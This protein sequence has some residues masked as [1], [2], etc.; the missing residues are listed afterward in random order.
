MPAPVAPD[1]AGAELAALGDALAATERE[2]RALAGALSPAQF[3]WRPAPGRWSVGE[4]LAHLNLVDASYLPHLDRMLARGRAAGLVARG[5]PRHPWLGRRL[6][7][8]VEPP[9]ALRIRTTAPYV[10]PS[11]VDRDG[12][13][14]EF[15]AVRRALQERVDAAAGLDP[16]RVRARYAVGI[17][18]AKLVVLSFGQWIALTAA[19]DRRHRWLGGRVAE[20]PG[21]P[22]R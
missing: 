13:L 9:V 18:P 8:G 14:A 16:G 4:H 22:A 1:P 12:A 6:V 19:H 10:P 21:F 3:N 7:A 11:T 2:W 17:G 20:S 15:A 5:A